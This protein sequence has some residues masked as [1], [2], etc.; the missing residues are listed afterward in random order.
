[1]ELCTWC[2]TKVA[3]S[4]D[5]VFPKCLGGKLTGG[6]SVRSCGDCQTKIS[7]AEQAIARHSPIA[8]ER[9]KRGVRPRNPSRL[10][11]GVIETEMSLVKDSTTNRYSGFVLRSG[12]STPQTLPALEIEVSSGHG[13]YQGDS[14]GDVNR[15]L[16]KLRK[17]FSSPPNDSEPVYKF[18]LK[19]LPEDWMMI[20]N[21]PDFNPRITMNPRG[22][23][24]VWAR[25]SDEGTR[26]IRYLIL[27]SQRGVLEDRTGENWATWSVPAGTEHEFH[28]VYNPEVICRVVLK[29]AFGTAIAWLRSNGHPDIECPAIRSAILGEMPLADGV[30]TSVASPPGSVERWKDSMV[31]ALPPQVTSGPAAVGL[32]GHWF[33]VRLPGADEMPVEALAFGAVCPVAGDFAQRWLSESEALS[34]LDA[35]G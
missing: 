28:I 8:L 10:E 6:L 23:I 1:M 30:V 4:K 2:K 29:V 11:S 16:E 24:E 35:F 22:K 7:R 27:L 19:E 31:S 13:W 3:K 18:N 5:H 17:L 14:I 32:F 33:Q 9:Y 12:S 26:F 21:D 34:A 20:R 25:D 15:M